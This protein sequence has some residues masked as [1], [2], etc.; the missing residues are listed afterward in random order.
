M[1][2]KNIRQLS[3]M[4]SSNGKPPEP[5]P[6]LPEPLAVDPHDGLRRGRE[7]AALY[8]ENLADLM[9]KLAFGEGTRSLH[10]RMEAGRT[11]WG[12]M[13][14]VPDNVPAPPGSGREG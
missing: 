13:Q 4:R 3:A 5:I 14:D 11:L 8:A 12:M 9:A 2:D 10:T 7:R 1:T 6:P